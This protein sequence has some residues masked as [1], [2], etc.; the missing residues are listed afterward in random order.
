M[1][2]TK[3]FETS[4]TGVDSFYFSAVTIT[5]LGYGEITPKTDLAKIIVTSE[6]LMGVVI[7]GLFLSSLWQHF[8]TQ[9]EAR[10]AQLLSEKMWIDNVRRLLDYYLFL[11]VCI[12]HFRETLVEVTTPMSLRSH[13]IFPSQNF[14]FSDLKDI[15]N[16]SM[17]LTFDFNKTVLHRYYIRQDQLLDELKYFLANFSLEQAPEIRS[18]I[19]ALLA[20][21]SAL[22]VRGA[23]IFY[24]EADKD[25]KASIVSMIV[26]NDKC[27]PL[28]DYKSNLLAPIILLD[29]LL[30]SQISMLENLEAEFLKLKNSFEQRSYK[31]MDNSEHKV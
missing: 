6:A 29:Q 17:S 10:Q 28:E 26:E 5:T 12:V 3:P 14:K 16:Q 27:P 23:V 24:S 31:N 20:N 2:S 25:L 21:A 1:C 22:D 7:L 9:V 13:Q 30:R 11:E 4:L 19:V 18:I 8:V 15:F